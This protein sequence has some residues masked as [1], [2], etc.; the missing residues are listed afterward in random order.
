M[1]FLLCQAAID[2]FCKSSHQLFNYINSLFCQT[3]SSSSLLYFC[4]PFWG[5]WYI[6]LLISDLLPGTPWSYTWP[7]VPTHGCTPW[8]ASLSFYCISRIQSS[9]QPRS[10]FFH[11]W[12]PAALPVTSRLNVPALSPWKGTHTHSWAWLQGK[13]TCVPKPQDPKPDTVPA[14]DSSLPGMRVGGGK[15]DAPTG[16]WEDGSVRRLSSESGSDQPRAS[17][18]QAPLP[19]V[20]QL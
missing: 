3:Y 19:Q 7:L 6:W 14:S 11:R 4:V 17:P 12:A 16:Q 2:C 20:P 18:L 8:L 10:S 13:W 5:F 1:L 9:L 15:A